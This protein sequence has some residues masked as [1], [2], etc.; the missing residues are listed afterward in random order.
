MEGPSCI[1]Q[2]PNQTMVVPSVA[3]VNS[4]IKLTENEGQ[5]QTQVKKGAKRKRGVRNPH[6]YKQEVIKNARLKGEKYINLKGV[7]VPGKITP[8]PDCL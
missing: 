8:G 1:G 3:I 7:E 4:K 6:L 2:D 5:G